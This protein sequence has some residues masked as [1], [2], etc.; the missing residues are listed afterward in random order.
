MTTTQIPTPSDD[1]APLRRTDSDHEE[2]GGPPAGRE[3]Q[4][5]DAAAKAEL[6]KIQRDLRHPDRASS[7]ATAAENDGAWSGDGE[8]TSRDA[9]HATAN[10]QLHNLHPSGEQPE[11]L[12]TEQTG[13]A[14]GA[15]P[16]REDDVPAEDR[17]WEDKTSI[18]PLAPAEEI[19]QRILV[20][21]KPE[22]YSRAL[23][24]SEGNSAGRVTLFHGEPGS[25]RYTC[26]LQWAFERLRLN[27]SQFGMY[28]YAKSPAREAKLADAVLNADWP[29]GGVV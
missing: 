16:F 25:G 17:R 18:R 5:I 11:A 20:F 13:E 2:P 23:K 22:S 6:D 7:E 9:P 4:Q 14:Q 10:S 12:G 3:N 21:C 8:F 19:A 28:R 24:R 27:W 29:R 1:A 26:A 15:D